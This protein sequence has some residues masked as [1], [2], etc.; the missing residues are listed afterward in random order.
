[1]AA[2]SLPIIDLHK[3][4]NY[5]RQAGI[6][7]LIRVPGLLF[8]TGLWF[9]TQQQYFLYLLPIGSPGCMI[10]CVL[11]HTYFYGSVARG[12][13]ARQA[14]AVK[15]QKGAPA[16][17]QGRATY[18]GAVCMIHCDATMVCFC[19]LLFPPGPGRFL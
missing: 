6:Y 5:S 2:V 10:A 7:L 15:A 11:Q 8:R 1:M 13:G 18:S 19:V 4:A 12:L 9:M 17:T 14:L 3:T 16:I